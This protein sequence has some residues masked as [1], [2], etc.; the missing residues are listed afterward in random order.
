MKKRVVVYHNPKTYCWLQQT[1]KRK[2]ILYGSAG[3]GKSWSIAQF[4]LLERMIKADNI[5]ILVTMKTRPQL[6]KACWNLFND[7]ILKYEL[8]GFSMN[9]SD[10]VLR[11]GSNEMYFVPLDDP[12]KLK[13]FER[14]NYIWA[15][16]ATSLSHLDYLQLDIRCRGEN[17]YGNNQLFFSFNPID[18]QSFFKGITDN[19]TSD[20]AIQHSTYKDNLHT[21]DKYIKQLENLIEHDETYYKIY[22][23]G[24]WATPEGII[25]TNWD[26][27][28]GM[29]TEQ[30]SERAWGLDFGYST[31]P[32][33]LVEIRFAG[34]E[35]YEH[36]H[37]Y[38]TGLTNPDII[39]KLES[40]IENK[41]DLI[42]ADSAEPKSI[43]EIKRAG[44]NI[45][46]CR[47][48][49]DS[50]K[51]GINAVKSYN[52]THITADS[53]DLIKEK[54]S[55]KWKEDKDGN[56]LDE[57]LKFHDHLMDAER[58]LVMHFKT[59]TEATIIFLDSDKAEHTEDA[60]WNILNNENEDAWI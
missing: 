1:K 14:I 47:K 12:E 6:K 41:S 49:K 39:R 25:Y 51:F 38:E 44:F 31:N 18:E 28:S 46:P 53:V 24:Q 15:E 33:A 43:E 5:R 54:K 37:I 16:E 45:H 11:F 52:K 34:N 9:K 17:S 35:I 48:G 29:P 32:C 3:S 59:L 7:L 60:E 2:N 40:I 58:Y 21:S 10:L 55:Y 8:E 27:V 56:I 57:P 20:T 22:T 50:V 4:L 19:P 23:L 30:F 36:E 26:I 42:I 13:S